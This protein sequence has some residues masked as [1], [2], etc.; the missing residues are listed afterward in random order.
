MERVSL[1]FG[2]LGGYGEVLVDGV[3]RGSDEGMVGREWRG[4]NH[5]RA[6][7]VPHEGM[8]GDGSTDFVDDQAG[9]GTVDAMDNHSFR[10]EGQHQID[11]GRGE[12]AGHV[13]Q[14]GVGQ[15]VTRF[16]GLQ[17]LG[18]RCRPGFCQLGIGVT[19]GPFLGEAQEAL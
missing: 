18:K 5:E 10:V 14:H 7:G 2:P 16:G 9:R 8:T 15:G 3:A 11:D 13:V 17:H 12:P 1:E 6:L 19:G 4:F